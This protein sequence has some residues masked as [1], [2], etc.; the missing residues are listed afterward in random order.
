MIKDKLTI[1][2]LLLL[3]LAGVLL[4]S[5]CRAESDSSAPETRQ[6]TGTTAAPYRRISAEQA[7]QMMEQAEQYILLDVRTEEEFKEK[8]IE[9]AILIPDYDIAAKA[10]QQLP[11]KQALILVYCRT[12]RRSELAARQLIVMGYTQVYD[13]GGIVDW[14]YET[15]SG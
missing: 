10:E 2:V 14:P 13:F 7:R 5:G 4:L 6:T 15:I 11:D 12:G 3:L 1:K 9:G 8:R